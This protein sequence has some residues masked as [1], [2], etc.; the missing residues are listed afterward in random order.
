MVNKNKNTSCSQKITHNK[1]RLSGNVRELNGQACE[2]SRFLIDKIF[3]IALVIGS[4]NAVKIKD[5]AE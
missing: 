3:R 2:L 5:V 4:P 1:L